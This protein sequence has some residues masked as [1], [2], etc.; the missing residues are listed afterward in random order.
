MG[1]G[2]GPIET[3]KAEADE[4]DGARTRHRD[5]ARDAYLRF[6]DLLGRFRVLDPACGFGNFLYLSLKHLKDFDLQ[7]IR[8]ARRSACRLDDQRVT[9]QT[10]LGIEINAYAAELARV[11][12]SIGELQW[13]LRNGFGIQ[14]S[15]ILGALNGIECRDA[16]LNADGSEADWPAADAIVGNPPFLGGKKLISTL[17]EDHVSKLFEAFDERVPADADLVCYWLYKAAQVGE[18]K[19]SKSRRSGCHQFRPWRSR[20]EGSSAGLSPTA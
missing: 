8:E 18:Q 12:I 13:Q 6:R 9:P 20:P 15:P 5:A 17:G 11:T 16:L 19:Q 7:V 14:R 1:G 3:G 4:D 10:V 2:E